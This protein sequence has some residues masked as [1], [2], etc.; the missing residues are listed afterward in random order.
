[1]AIKNVCNKI[2]GQNSIDL[3]NFWISNVYNCFNTFA[4]NYGL[5]YCHDGVVNFVHQWS[6]GKNENGKWEKCVTINLKLWIKNLHK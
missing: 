5:K 4:I 1:M 6:N 3:N 2:R